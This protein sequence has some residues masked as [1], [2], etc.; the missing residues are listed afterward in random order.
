M[1]EI[2][3]DIK[4]YEDLYQVSNL[5]RVKSL[6]RY[7]YYTN[8]RI[9]LY[10][11]QILK[12]AKD[13]HGY[14]KITLCKDTKHTTCLIHRLVAEAFI[15]NLNNLPQVN[16]KDEFAKDNNCVDNLEW[17][18]CK[19]NINYGTHNKRMANTQRGKTISKETRN[20]I[21]KNHIKSERYKGKNNPSAK[22]VRCVTTGEIFDYIK[23][24]SDKYNIN[25]QHI[26]CCCK[27][28]RKSCG[29]LS[30]GTKLKWEYIN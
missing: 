26:S 25:G 19:E 15:Q 13:T 8:G 9:R 1:E 27:G 10:R 12:T 18:T 11:G 3:R 17:V 7:I 14:L 30:N 22:R 24:A 20:K 29:K 23:L 21:S 2:W 4:G 28:K 16:H 6:D 5:G